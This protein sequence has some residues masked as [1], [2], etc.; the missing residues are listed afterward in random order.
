MGSSRDGSLAHLRG[1][2]GNL[3][4]ENKIGQVRSGPWPGSCCAEHQERP[5]S[6]DDHRRSA[7]KS[8]GTGK[9]QFDRMG[10]DQVHLT[11]FLTGDILR[12]FQK[13]WARTFFLRDS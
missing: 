6:L 1:E 11:A 13:N 7:I 2:V 9:R 4:P 3:G 5:P 10:R 12:E 8:I